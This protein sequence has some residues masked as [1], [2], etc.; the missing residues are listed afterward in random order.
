[1]VD[2]ARS[3]TALDDLE[4]LAPA[5]EQVLERHA[6]ILIDDLHVAL[7]R[8]VV[9]KHLHR[10]H[11]LDAGRVGGDDDHALLRVAIRVVGVV[12]A[13][14]QVHGAARV[15][16]ARDPPLVPVDDNLV[17]LLPQR[18]ADVGGVGRGDEA[19]RHG[20]RAGASSTTGE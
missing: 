17:A 9:A 19:L 1:V 11:D 16:R 14:E 18:R 5:H 20:K 7:G 3:Q 8:I 12:L 13:H 4:A 15:A 6:H 10:A 2:A